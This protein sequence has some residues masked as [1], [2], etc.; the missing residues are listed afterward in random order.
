VDISV[1]HLAGKQ[2]TPGIS[3]EFSLATQLSWSLC[4][5]IGSN[6]ILLNVRFEIAPAVTYSATVFPADTN[7]LWAASIATPPLHLVD[8][9]F[10]QTGSVT[11]MEQFE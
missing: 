9:D 3:L 11:L 10:E 4:A 7:K 2:S 6:K 1:S 8:A 5:S